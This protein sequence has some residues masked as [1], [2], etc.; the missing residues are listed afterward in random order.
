MSAL[1]RVTEHIDVFTVASDGIVY[2]IW[3]DGATGWAAFRRITLPLL[4]PALLIAALF[5]YIF[6][7]RLFSEV[8]LLTQGGPARS[9]EVV[10]VYLYLEAF[11]YNSF[12]TAAA[13]AWIM[14]VV[15]LILATGYIWMLRR[16]VACNAR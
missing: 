10:A 9:T 8:W 7:F 15:S 14:V 3:R 2:S 4:M 1:S 5:R 16:Q 13:T 6:A 11:R 12:G